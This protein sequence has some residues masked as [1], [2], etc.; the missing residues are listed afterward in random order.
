MSTCKKSSH[1]NFNCNCMMFFAEV[2]HM[3][4]QLKL[5]KKNSDSKMATQ[6]NTVTLRS[7]FVMQELCKCFGDSIWNSKDRQ[8]AYGIPN[9]PRQIGNAHMV[10]QTSQAIA[11]GSALHAVNIACR[12]PGPLPRPTPCPRHAH[13]MPTQ[14]TTPQVAHH[15]L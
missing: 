15:M 2:N 9:K 5:K 11:V 7:C 14:C 8:C 4:P 12:Q 1:E 13:A 6:V 10:Y 3:C